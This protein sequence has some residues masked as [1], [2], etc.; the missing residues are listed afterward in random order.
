MQEFV[1][2]I[3]F[4][5]TWFGK[6]GRLQSCGPGGEVAARLC[7]KGVGSHEDFL[8]T[9]LRGGSLVR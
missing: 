5:V 4:P 3:F 6:Q 2:S 8:T 9:I 7:T 1:L